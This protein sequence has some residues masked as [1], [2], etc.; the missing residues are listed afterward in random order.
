[1]RLRADSPSTECSLREPGLFL[2]HGAVLLSLK[3]ADTQ[4]K[5]S[6]S[7]STEQIQT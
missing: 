7:S 4:L 5:W 1:M 2:T 6:V 3:L